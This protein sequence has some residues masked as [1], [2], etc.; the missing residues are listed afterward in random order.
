M[1][2]SLY[3]T[4][5]LQVFTSTLLTLYDH[6][7]INLTNFHARIAIVIAIKLKTSTLVGIIIIVNTVQE[8]LKY[9]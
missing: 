6:A 2:T 7:S 9:K 1:W 8:L 3:A 4:F 5:M